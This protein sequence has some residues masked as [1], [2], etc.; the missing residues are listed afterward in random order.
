M[1]LFRHVASVT[2]P[3]FVVPFPHARLGGG[4]TLNEGGS[5]KKNMNS[6]H[7]S[8]HGLP[9]VIDLDRFHNS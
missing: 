5:N 1:Q 9:K 4:M 7:T 3:V 8:L 6:T 2:A